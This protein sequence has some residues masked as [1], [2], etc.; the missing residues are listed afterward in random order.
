MLEISLGCIEKI[1]C[2]A[3]VVGFT[4]GNLSNPLLVK[5]KE[6]GTRVAEENRRVRR[7]E[8]L[9]MPGSLKVVNDLEKR[10]LPL[11]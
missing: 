7:D 9:R 11:R 4:V 8:E 1:A 5:A 3:I 6:N 2:H 10:Q